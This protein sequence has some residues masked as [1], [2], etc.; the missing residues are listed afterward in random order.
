MKLE[1]FIVKIPA[2]ALSVDVVIE[3]WVD[4]AAENIKN[5]LGVTAACTADVV[6]LLVGTDRAVLVV[7]SAVIDL[8]LVDVTKSGVLLSVVDKYVDLAESKVSIVAALDRTVVNVLDTVVGLAV[9]TDFMEPFA[10][11]DVQA[12]LQAT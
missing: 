3:S 7:W 8:A 6:G 10:V 2:A 9:D 5:M 1:V 12:V 11:I 4:I